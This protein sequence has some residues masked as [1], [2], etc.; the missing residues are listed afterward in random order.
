MELSGKEFCVEFFLI[1]FVIAVTALSGIQLSST[2]W[3]IE[4]NKLKRPDP[5]GPAAG[6]TQ[7]RPSNTLPA[8]NVPVVRS[9]SDICIESYCHYYFY[10]SQTPAVLQN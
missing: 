2:D 4:C 8:D 10:F 3:T 5:R 6:N 1:I 7:A 9:H